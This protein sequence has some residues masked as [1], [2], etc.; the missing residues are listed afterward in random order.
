MFSP[1]PAFLLQLFYILLSDFAVQNA[2]W[3]PLY[4]NTPV[5]F[6][7]FHKAQNCWTWPTSLSILI[8][9]LYPTTAHEISRNN[10]PKNVGT[11]WFVPLWNTHFSLSF[12]LFI[13]TGSHALAQA[14]LERLFIQCLWSSWIDFWRSSKFLKLTHFE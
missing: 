6:L 14:G 12:S 9:Y 13:K 7:L 10:P 2:Y 11:V 8:A 1:L 5:Y 4:L 3:P